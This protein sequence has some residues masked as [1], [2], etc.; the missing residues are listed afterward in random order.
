M[1]AI[2]LL[3]LQA[4]AAAYDPQGIHV[5]PDGVL[6]SRSVDPDPRLAETRRN[7]RQAPAQDGLLY[8]SLPKLFT[9]ARRLREAK[10]P[11]PDEIRYLG[12]LTKLTYVFA[13]PDE[14]DLVIAGPSEPIDAR[15][16]YRP[17][18][19]RTG[20]PLMHLDDLVTAI[21]AFAPGRRPDRLGCDI[22]ITPEIR[23]RVAAKIKAIGPTARL[24]GFQKTCDRIAEA[25]G[26]QPVKYYGMDPDTRFAFV[27]VEA[28]YRLKQLALGYWPSPVKEVPSYKS[29]LLVPEMELRFSLESSYEALRASPDG[30]AFE[31]KGP[32]LKVNGGRLGDPASTVQDMTPAGRTFVEACN[33]HLDGLTR[34]LICWSDLMNLADLSVLAALLTGGDRL[35]ER[36]GWDLG[37]ILDPAACE[38]A[39]MPAPRSAATLCAIAVS[40]NNAIFVTGGIWIKPAEW[41]SKRAPDPAFAPSGPRPSAA[42]SAR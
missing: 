8:I 28:D 22:D 6:R 13:Y 37:W 29:L 4:G 24:T 16:A 9:E 33:A 12:G 10:K 7:A 17:L 38:I 39:R 34:T 27:C 14:K 40:G 31:L 15:D 18:G 5:D 19:R 23:E 42:W 2:V 20:R 1:S 32:S 21:R 3:L 41:M 35:A 25:G 11:L 26:P 36:T 30:T